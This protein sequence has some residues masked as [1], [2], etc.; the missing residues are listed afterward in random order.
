[1]SLFVGKKLLNGGRD[2]LR[3]FQPMSF[4]LPANVCMFNKFF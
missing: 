3:N 1:M 4:H 2:A